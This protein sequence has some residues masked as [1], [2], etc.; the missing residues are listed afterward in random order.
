MANK[1]NEYI[2][3]SEKILLAELNSPAKI[4]NFLDSKIT[5]DPYREDRCV[6]EVIKDRSAECFNGALFALGCLL[7]HGYKASLIEL[8]ARD[9]EEHILCVYEVGGRYGSIA[10]SKFLGL[11]NRNPMYISLR[12]LV[13]SYIEFYFAF[14]G[15]YSLLSYTN[16]LPLAKYKNR[17]WFD[18]NIVIQ[19]A[20]DLRSLKHYN[21]IDPKAP[22]FYVSYDRYWKDVDYIPKEVKIPKRYLPRPKK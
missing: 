14:D 22:F 6:S 5:Y 8:L 1:L 18:R 4:Q 10:Q 3:K 2:P 20:K 9:D 16:F 12:D 7:Y 11:K 15:H 17:W 19:M 21:L 13:A